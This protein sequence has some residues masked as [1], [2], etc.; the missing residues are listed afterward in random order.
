[1]KIAAVTT[2]KRGLQKEAALEPAL[3]PG[4]ADI[5]GS[6]PAFGAARGTRSSRRNLIDQAIAGQQST[7]AAI[8]DL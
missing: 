2:Q 7:T 3:R 1:M 5:L 4:R 8:T 6:A